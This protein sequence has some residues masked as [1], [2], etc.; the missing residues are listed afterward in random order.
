MLAPKILSHAT[1]AR[2]NHFTVCAPPN[3]TLQT[4]HSVP[5]NHC[6]VFDFPFSPQSQPHRDT[7]THRTMTRYRGFLCVLTS[8]LVPAMANLQQEKEQLRTVVSQVGL[9]HIFTLSTC[10]LIDSVTSSEYRTLERQEA[11]CTVLKFA[12]KMS[13][14]SGRVP[15]HHSIFA[16]FFFFPGFT[17]SSCFL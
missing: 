15:R 13:F 12:C 11:P 3:K 7:T 8:I 14:E 17:F 6:A 2:N 10:I 9:L 1:V 16:T 4:R 5:H